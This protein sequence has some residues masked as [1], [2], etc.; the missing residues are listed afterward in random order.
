[1]SFNASDDKLWLK[2]NEKHFTPK[3][4]E[5]STA[6]SISNISKLCRFLEIDIQSGVKAFSSSIAWI[7]RA[8][9][10]N[11]CDEHQLMDLRSYSFHLTT[12]VNTTYISTRCNSCVH[13]SFCCSRCAVQRLTHEM[14]TENKSI[15]RWN[16]N[17]MN[18]CALTIRTLNWKILKRY[19]R[20]ACN[21]FAHQP[22]QRWDWRVAENEKKTTKLQRPTS[23]SRIYNVFK[24]KNN[25]FAQHK[26][27]V[28]PE[29]CEILTIFSKFS[30]LKN[31]ST[32]EANA[33][34]E[35]IGFCREKVRWDA[36]A[37]VR[38]RE[39]LKASNSH[40]FAHIKFSR[41]NNIRHDHLFRYL[42]R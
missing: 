42:N 26:C 15:S 33:R 30:M 3:R 25:A 12:V 14:R 7:L 35:R 40:E 4:T 17:T 39:R 21:D 38:V 11:F 13:G 20:N 5:R 32:T 41:A 1:M 24:N 16:D 29:Y 27:V 36:S 18:L 2:K 10:H 34:K 19:S 22:R 37:S 31:Y 9:K 28:I 23:S 8:S 6:M